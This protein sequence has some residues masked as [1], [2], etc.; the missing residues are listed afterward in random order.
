[1]LAILSFFF[2]FNFDYDG[3]SIYVDKLQLVPSGGDSGP[4]SSERRLVSVYS[5]STFIVSFHSSFS[6]CIFNLFK[7]CVYIYS[8]SHL[9]STYLRQFAVPDEEVALNISW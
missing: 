2:F 5:F 9:E 8:H 6:A 7:L 4:H 3:E 1:M